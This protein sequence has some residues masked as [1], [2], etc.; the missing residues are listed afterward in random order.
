MS[1][2]AIAVRRSSSNVFEDLGLPNAETHFLKAQ[3]VAELYELKTEQGLT[4]AKAGAL[5]GITQPEVSRMFERNFREYSIEQLLGF[6]S[7]FDQEV[8]IVSRPRTT[9]SPSRGNI[10]FRPAQDP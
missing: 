8:E 1:K 10:A 4:Q 3:I 5:M 9:C 2:R 6:L 7:A